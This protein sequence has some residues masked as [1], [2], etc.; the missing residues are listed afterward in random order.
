MAGRAKRSIFSSSAR[1]RNMA[2]ITHA[3]DIDG[4]A[5]AALISRKFN[6]P[7]SNLFFSD[8]SAGTLHHIRSGLGK[9]HNINALFITDLSM[10]K[11]LKR[12]FLEIIRL[13]KGRSGKIFWFDHHPWNAEDIRDMARLCDSIV[14][15]ENERYCATEITAKELGISDTFSR[16]LLRIV[17]YSDFNIPPRRTSERLLIGRYALSITYYNSAGSRSLADKRLRHIAEV[18]RSNKLSDSAIV[19]DAYAFE[20]IN[21]ERTERMLSSLYVSK[22]SGIAVG[23]SKDIQSTAACM[24]IIKKGR[25]GVGVYINTRNSTGHIRSTDADSSPLARALGG[26][27]HP[28]ASGFRLKGHI[29]SEAARR[30]IAARIFS[31]WERLSK[32]TVTCKSPPL[33]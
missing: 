17:H 20:R 21:S 10:N 3:N 25:T 8:Y 16:T 11:D 19:H 23:F 28:H 22:G 24:A 29:E 15:G 9:S 27:G 30:S 33:R 6:V 7:L 26:N 2:V 31:A 18:L 4:I 12:N 13:V 1:G 5:S 32:N 14:A